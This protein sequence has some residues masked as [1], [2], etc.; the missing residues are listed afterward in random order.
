M[1][2][3]IAE[4]TSILQVLLKSKEAIAVGAEVA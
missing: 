1:K 3:K 2:E 4:Y